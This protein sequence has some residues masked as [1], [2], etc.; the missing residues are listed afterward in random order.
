MTQTSA[1]AVQRTVFHIEITDEHAIVLP[2][3]LREQLGLEA[4]D[5]VAISVFGGRGSLYKVP[6]AKAAEPVTTEPIPEARGLLRDYF[7]DSEDVRR[8][9]AEERGEVVD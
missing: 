6:K 9:L 5:V 1:P 4:G 7:K 8:F 3:D 2:S